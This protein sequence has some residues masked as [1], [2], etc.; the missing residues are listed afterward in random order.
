MIFNLLILLK[1]SA[2]I[3]VY[4]RMIKFEHSIFALPFALSALLLAHRV[5]PVTPRLV[6]WIIMAVVWARSAGM[7]FNQLVDAHWDAKNP[8]TA[9]REIPAG[10]ISLGETGVFVCVSS[11]LFVLSALA[12]SRLCFWFSFP[13]LL[14]LCS[15]SYTKRYTGLS[16]LI[17]G[18]VQALGPLGVWLAV[19]GNLSLKIAVLSLTLGTYIAGFDLLYACQDTEFDRRE[20]LYSVPANLGIRRALN[21]SIL[22]HAITF[23]SLLSLYWVFTLS[24]FYLAYVIIIGLLLVVEHKIVQPDDLSR[25]NIAFFHVN[26]V[27]SVLLLAAMLTEE[28]LRRMNVS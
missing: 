26:S 1:A 11:L 10:H 21:F 25:I 28:L 18:F 6:F 19:T 17:L 13:V 4:G 8:R 9:G 24:H 3:A 5:N 16:H 23:V 20:G 7:G 15:Y 22:L 14:I 27:I 12:I 2:K